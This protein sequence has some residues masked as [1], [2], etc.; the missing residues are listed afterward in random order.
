MILLL[1]ILVA[2]LIFTGLIGYNVVHNWRKM[3]ATLD[4]TLSIDPK[5]EVKSIHPTPASNFDFT[6]GVPLNFKA[7]CALAVTLRVV[8]IV[9][10]LAAIISGLIL[11]EDFGWGIFLAIFLLG[12]FGCLFWYALAK[13][14]DAADKFL[15][16]H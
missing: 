2:L 8:G 5:S 10:I 12:C 7:P 15:N 14:V 16:S 11:L 6:R 1:V 3:R 13:C 4:R 9:T